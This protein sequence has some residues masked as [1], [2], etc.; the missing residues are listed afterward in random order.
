MNLVAD[1]FVVASHGRAVDLASGD[2]VALITSTSGGPTEQTQ[3]AIRCDWFFRLRH[4][5]IARL[6]DYG[7]LRGTERFEAWCCGGTW[8][9]PR[10]ETDRVLGLAASFLRANG[11][12]QGTLS[13]SAVRVE[14]GRPLVLPGADTGHRDGPPS[15]TNQLVLDACGIRVV[16]RRA[17][18]TI[19]ELFAEAGGCRPRT[20]A[21]Y[22][23]GGAGLT[24]A[25]GELS[26]AA[27]VSGFVPL[28]LNAGDVPN[29]DLCQDRSLFLIAAGRGTS[30]RW[31]SVV[32]WTIRSPRP[33]VVLFTGPDE[34][35]DVHA[36]RLEPL[37]AR[38][39]TEAFRPTDIDPA[40]RRRV[41]VAA[42][43]ARG[44][45]GRFAALLWGHV[46][47][48]RRATMP[49][50]PSLAAEQR[51]SYGAD[52]VPG[53]PGLQP[54][55][56]SSWSSPG[57]L[58][59][60]KRKMGAAIKQLNA[61]RHAPGGRTLRSAVAGLARRHDWGHAS[62][63]A[64]AL[65]S[66]VLRRGR[67]RD[68]Q[69]VL[70]EAKEYSRK[71]G[72]DSRMLDVAVLSGLA[73][74][75]LGRLDEAESVLSASLEAACSSGDVVRA[76]SIRLALARCL[77]WKGQYEG[78][79]RTLEAIDDHEVTEATAVRRAIA[80]SRVAIGYRDL[81]AGVTQA[82]GALEAAERLGDASLVAH[83]ACG[84]AFAHLVNGD[85]IALERDV[86]ASVR[87]ARV[88]RD[89][90]QALRARLIAAESGRRAGRKAAAEK[91]VGRVGKVGVV[92]LPVTVSARCALLAE[93]LSAASAPE[94]VKRHV[95]ASGLGALALFAPQPETDRRHE[96]RVAVSDVVDVLRLCQSAD[97][98]NA[99]LSGLC[100]L[101]R[102]R[103]HA[104]AIAFF[105]ADRGSLVALAHDG[106]SRLEPDIAA[107]AMAAGQPIAPHVRHDVLEG[108]APVRYGGET[109]GALV[110]RWTLGTTHDL[111]RASMLLTTAATAAGP[112][113]AGALLRRSD[114]QARG[115]GDLLGVS[116]AIEEVARA[117]ERAATAPF[118]VL[119][120]GES[121]S[122]KELV[123]RALHRRSQRRDRPFCTL[124]CAA[125][126]DDLVESEL[127]GHA[128]G[129]FT[130]AVAE[131]PG[132]FEEAHTGTLFLDEIGELSRRAQA[133]ILRTIQ[134][135]ELRRVG[136]NVARRVDV[137]IVSATN[138]DLRHEAAEGRFR[139]D[140]MYRLDIVRISV[141]PLRERREDIAVLVERF[142][143]DATGRVGSRAVLSTAT[144][145]ALGRYDWPGNVR[146]LQNVL[147]ALAV[148]SPRRGVIPP[149]AL[150]PG[151]G[152]SQPS[153]TWRLEEARRTFEESFVRA[154]LVRTGGHRTRAAE[155]LGVTRQG[156]TKLM[157][158]L[159]IMEAD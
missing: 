60:L 35:P 134:E 123:A 7:L 21:L 50:S 114:R 127:F 8:R 78:A 124:N 96:V 121:G 20:V 109:V 85:H 102:T 44:W 40:V 94:A 126:P 41:E 128:R 30:R 105:T 70:A 51:A 75:D 93:L 27:R 55:A 37:T 117:I 61:G 138:R 91:L 84:A 39:L 4:R 118:A 145:A 48:E 83:A 29:L 159:G 63:G 88:A 17:V 28:S 10:E 157:T 71:A 45:P 24:T 122:G 14:R 111:A 112:A 25:V 144:L 99:V 89:P 69:H 108:G 18:G 9:G 142:W 137:R 148:R 136:E 62:E 140:L 66:S 119:V 135:G 80:L 52:A 156:L 143:R 107:R 76:A 31:P 26:R 110:A 5:A 132:V 56:P 92:R 120:E 32:E 153:V 146:E 130:G 16:E 72:D 150:P 42:R 36:V 98:D 77:F 113:L 95:A 158:R 64:L 33:H 87:A 125:L 151:F 6:V 97:E 67:P 116:R 57:E 129:A 152:A 58:A 73:W 139:A 155:E 2:E 81:E 3:W 154:A 141:P 149:T 68:A 59:A 86:A 34:I 106:S 47:E 74:T 131:R 15:I 104:A 23:P 133:K 53:P 82:I 103:L 115:V 38:M 22:G 19:A 54:V 1:R 11:M 90:L 46:P 65:A 12:T 13:E 43:R 49:G 100:A 101:L 79:G 147:A